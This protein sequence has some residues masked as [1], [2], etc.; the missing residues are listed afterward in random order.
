MGAFGILVAL[1]HRD[2]SGRG[3]QIDLALY[4]PLLRMIEWQVP[5]Y[6][7]LGVRQTRNGPRFP[8]DGAFITDICRTRDDEAFVVS[9]A[10]AG[11]LLAL[12]RL[13]VST[14]ALTDPSAG[15]GRAGPGPA[16]RRGAA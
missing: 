15:E 5:L 10:T 4:E 1:R 12:R 3:Q 11:S 9:A 8:F 16:H 14:G 6:D 7:L 13:L 2:Q